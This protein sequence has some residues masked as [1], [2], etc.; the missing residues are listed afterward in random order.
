[1]SWRSLPWWALAPPMVAFDDLW[2][3]T[4]VATS[5]LVGVTS[6]V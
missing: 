2:C 1:M 4:M 6:R 3:N 5:L